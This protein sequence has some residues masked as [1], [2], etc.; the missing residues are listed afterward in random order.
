MPR[1][2]ALLLSPWLMLSMACA[3][4]ETAV[5]EPGAAQATQPAV[6]PAGDEDGAARDA[7]PSVAARDGLLAPSG[8]RLPAPA[9]RSATLVAFEPLGPYPGQ[10]AAQ[11]EA[12]L[13]DLRERFYG[14][15]DEARRAQLT[16]QLGKL[17]IVDLTGAYID[18]VI[19]LDMAVPDDVALA[20]AIVTEWFDRQ[21]R[22]KQVILDTNPD[23]MDGSWPQNRVAILD[24]WRRLWLRTIEDP[25]RV[26]RYRKRVDELLWE[27]RRLDLGPVSGSE[28]VHEG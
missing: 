3:T 20:G 17:H 22:Y 24:G 14:R 21:Q 18:L 15:P 1:H 12:A 25:E 23:R 6:A 9:L 13:A 8:R 10:P 5:A 28:P 16:A 7:S 26:A 2:A 27:R 4:T 11:Y 19:G